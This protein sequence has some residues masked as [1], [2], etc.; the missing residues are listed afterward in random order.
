MTEA[1]DCAA[2]TR[3]LAWE[4]EVGQL[5]QVMC[6]DVGIVAVVNSTVPALPLRFSPW[7]AMVSFGAAFVVGVVSGGVPARRVAMLDP[8]DALRYE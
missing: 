8:V 3:R 6:V 5:S 7:I 2:M 4:H 1:D